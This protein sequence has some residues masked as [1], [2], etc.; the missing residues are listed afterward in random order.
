MA[1]VGKYVSV[2][3]D[4][5]EGVLTLQQ[6]PPN[7]YRRRKIH[8]NTL[9]RCGLPLKLN[10]STIIQGL[11]Y[12]RVILNNHTT[13][14][15]V[16]NQAKASIITLKYARQRQL[17]IKPEPVEYLMADGH[18]HTSLGYVWMFCGRPN[19]P[20]TMKLRR[21]DVFPEGIH[22]VVLGEHFIY[23]TGILVAKTASLDAV[24][25][26]LP[27]GSRWRHTQSYVHVLLNKG[28]NIE[29]VMAIL[30]KGSNINALSLEC[31]KSLGFSSPSLCN[32]HPRYLQ[33][34]NGGKVQYEGTMTASVS[35]GVPPKWSRQRFFVIRNLPYDLGLGNPFITKRELLRKSQLKWTERS[36]LHPSC[37]GIIR[38]Q[39]FGMK[40]K[41][42]S[43]QSPISITSKLY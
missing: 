4:A 1:V 26:S 27:V 39:T 14:A 5:H 34:A 23:E 12:E 15:L 24:D 43:S 41:G 25:L 7:S 35:L 17:D 13:L 2:Q 37:Y 40:S 21:F 36:Q 8:R 38:R 29:K 31:A 16:D 32:R 3:A 22:P 11:H 19:T 20:Q 9:H 10:R 30:D 18:L 6:E 42:S 28:S 33:I